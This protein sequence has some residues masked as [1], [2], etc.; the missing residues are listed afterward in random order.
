MTMLC[1]MCL[2]EVTF[3]QETVRG[4]S[5]FLCPGCN[6]P[7]PALYIKEYR[8][9]PPVVMSA[10]GFRQH[11][12]TVYFASLF[13]LL[14]KMRMARH[15][16]RFFTMGLDEES[17]RTV[18]ENVGMLEGGHLPDATPANFPRPTLVRVEGIPHQPNCTLIFYDTSGESFE[19]PTRLVRD[20]R[21]VQRAKTAMLL[22]SVPDMADPSRD[23]HKLLNTYIVGMAELG[24]ET[25]A[26]HLCVVYT[27]ADQMGE[28]MKKWTDIAR[29]LGDGS[30]ERLAQPLKYYEQMALISDRLRAFTRHELEADEFLNA[31]RAY[32]RGVS[33]SM[34]SS[35]GARP[36][37][38]DL[39]VQ[40]MPRRVLDPVLWTIESSL[41]D[42]W[43]G[44]KRWM[45]GWGA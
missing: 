24:A 14:K 5:V 40:V 21:F 26:Q 38:K 42:P 45:Q 2:A 25:R 1:P 4:T 33:F 34:V 22:L 39:T 20:A 32:F 31:T 29:Y 43:R 37:G 13:H 23:L 35:L 27:K 3:K 10:V 16:Q 7:V 8:Q 15:W 36:Q 28:R 12:K 11:G 19:Q 41:P 9:Y 6:Q 17:L 44:V 30:I 18:Y